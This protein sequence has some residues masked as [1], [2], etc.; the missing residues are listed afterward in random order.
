ML[1]MNDQEEDLARKRKFVLSGWAQVVAIV[2][3]ILLGFYAAN[4][5]HHLSSD[6]IKFLLSP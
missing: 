3:V 1:A 2:I 6:V 4:H 5:P